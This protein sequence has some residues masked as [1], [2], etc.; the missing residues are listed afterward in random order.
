MT[1]RLRE[2][3]RIQQIRSDDH[4]KQDALHLAQEEDKLLFQSLSTSDL[5]SSSICAFRSSSAE[6]TCSRNFAR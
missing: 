4:Q 1:F 5:G 2:G 6:S 3:E